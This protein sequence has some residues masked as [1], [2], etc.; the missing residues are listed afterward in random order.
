M[1]HYWESLDGFM[2]Y[3]TAYRRMLD[4]LPKDRLSAFVEIGC[5]KGK[6][7]AF[8]GVEI[9]NRNI[10]V[11]VH[12]VDNWE[13]PNGETGQG[14]AIFAEFERNIKPIAD[15]LGDRLIV[16]PVSSLEAS[17]AFLD[18]S[19]D[20]VWVDADHE[21]E[22]CLQD[23]RAWWPKIKPGGFMGGDDFMMLGV[24]RAVCEQFAPNY[25]CVHGWTTN[26]SPMPWPSWITRKA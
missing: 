17:M 2:W 26:P 19:L 20:V 18:N 4:T 21:Y 24:A 5:Y 1:D 10:P 23:I 8:L 22:G 12:C 16:H 7:T 6:S 15:A 14:P 3:E 13:S 25:I 9:V 11:T